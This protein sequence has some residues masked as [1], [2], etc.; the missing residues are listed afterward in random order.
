MRN[1]FYQNNNYKNLFDIVLLFNKRTKFDIFPMFIVYNIGI[2]LYRDL[3]Q[4]QKTH[5]N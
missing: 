1:Y 4:N 3:N 5:K 2:I